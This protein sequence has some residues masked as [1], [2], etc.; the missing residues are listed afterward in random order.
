[1]AAKLIVEVGQLLLR[2]QLPFEEEVG[3]F[4][5]AAFARQ[6]FDGD[7]PIFQT[8]IFPVDEAHLPFRRR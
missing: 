4:L 2:G 6:G 1:M 7:A 5:E 8:G 3:R